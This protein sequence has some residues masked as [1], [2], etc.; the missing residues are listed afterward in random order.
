MAEYISYC[1]YLINFVDRSEI[2]VNFEID[3]VEIK[4]NMQKLK[5]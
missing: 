3:S 1:S 5:F 4:A 2:L